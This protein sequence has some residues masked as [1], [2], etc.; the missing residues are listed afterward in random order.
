MTTGAEHSCPQSPHPNAHSPYNYT[1]LS[2]T[3]HTYPHAH[4]CYNHKP[5]HP[6]VPSPPTGPHPLVLSP[7]GFSLTTLP[8]ALGRM[9]AG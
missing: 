4:G 5:S 2:T 8:L 9:A 6:C 7:R 3:P 1:H